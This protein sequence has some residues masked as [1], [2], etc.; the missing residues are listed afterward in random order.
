MVSAFIGGRLIEFYS[1][2]TLYFLIGIAALIGGLLLMIYK[3]V[4]IK[5]EE[6]NESNLV[7]GSLS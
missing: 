2:F 7:P 5:T 1:V 3:Y 4:I 6:N